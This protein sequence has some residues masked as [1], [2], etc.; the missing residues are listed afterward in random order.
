MMKASDLEKKTLAELKD[1]CKERN[2]DGTGRKAQVIQRLVEHA[3]ASAS[4]SAP[5]AEPVAD[6]PVVTTEAPTTVQAPAPAPVAPTDQAKPPQPVAVTAPSPSPAPAAETVPLASPQKV[7]LPTADILT[8]PIA[9]MTE[10]E[11]RELRKA[12]YGAT[13][14]FSNPTGEK[15][16]VGTQTAELT[17]GTTQA[18]AGGSDDL[19]LKRK[20]AERFGIPLTPTQNRTAVGLA[21]A[22][23]LTGQKRIASAA[24]VDDAEEARKKARL[25]RFG[26][27]AAGPAGSLSEQE[28]AK[29]KRLQRFGM[30]K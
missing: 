11:K 10:E 21:T 2:L 14:P 7:V 29:Q 8:K 17:A 16:S 30:A 19:E 4:T 12:K 6:A 3:A 22:T 20:R 1:L 13:N 25:E 23:P 9:A 27:S 24:V 28:L 26:L 5:A 15:K 18:S